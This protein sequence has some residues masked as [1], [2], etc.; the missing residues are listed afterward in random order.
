M[1]LREI[2]GRLGVR[3]WYDS[4]RA[5][6]G[7]VRPRT[8]LMTGAAGRI[9][10]QIRPLL[11]RAYPW[12]RLTDCQAITELAENEEFQPADLT[13]R[14]SV[15]RVVAGVEGIIHLGGIAGEAA[16][17]QLLAVNVS[18]TINLFESARRHGVSRIVFASTLHVLGFYD[19]TQIIS[20]DSAPR[21]D[22]RYAVSKLFGENLGR[23][24]ADKYGM[25]VCCLRI[26]HA[27]A[28]RAEAEPDIW[29]GPLDL[30]ALIRIGLEHPDVR[31]EILHAVA[32]Y[33]GSDIGQNRARRIYG[34]VCREAGGDYGAAQSE[35]TRWF[36]GDAIA[37]RVRGGVFA[38]TDALR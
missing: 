11:A 34:W 15:E 21:P 25:R 17:D 20:P 29:I 12:V 30:V 36:P 33:T 3:Q 26:G 16:F 38:S 4:R 31:F 6:P 2:L 1:V 19:R 23:L 32:Q 13:D 18:G 10:S 24:Y 22:S 7:V 9:A 8:I 28:T 35:V 5:I 14:D 37:R 27:V